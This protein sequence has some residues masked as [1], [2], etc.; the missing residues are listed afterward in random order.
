MDSLRDR[1]AHVEPPFPMLIFE[2]GMTIRWVSRAV[3]EEFGLQPDRVLGRTW[4]ELFPESHSRSA[5]H[6]ELFAGLRPQLDRFNVTLPCAPNRHFSLRLRP[7]RD[8]DG[9]IEFV[10]GIA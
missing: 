1:L 3:T 2:R 5:A 4:Y 8:T 10:A 6:E 7:V 9:I